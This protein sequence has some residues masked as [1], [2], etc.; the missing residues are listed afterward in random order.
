MFFSTFIMGTAG[1]MA[2]QIAN[3]FDELATIQ[4]FFVLPASFLSGTFFSIE[5]CHWVLNF[6]SGS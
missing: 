1:L 5:T 4:N 2:G 3:K 6:L